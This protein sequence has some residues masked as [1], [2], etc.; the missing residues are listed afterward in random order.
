MS[1]SDKK[2]CPDAERCVHL[3]LCA[4]VYQAYINYWY[5]NEQIGGTICV[6]CIYEYPNALEL[7]RHTPRLLPLIPIT[8]NQLPEKPI[9]FGVGC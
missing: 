7:T 3:P 8:T 9:S 1:L 6:T 2:Y 4:I 5:T